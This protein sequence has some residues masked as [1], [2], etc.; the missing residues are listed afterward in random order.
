MAAHQS[1][2]RTESDSLG[3]IEIDAS[4]LWGAQTERSVRNF[5]AGQPHYVWGRGVIRSIGLVKRAAASANLDAGVLEPE[6][7]GLIDGAAS[8]VVDGAL[9]DHFPLV[10]FQT[11]SGTQ[12]NMNGNEVIANRANQRAGEPLGTKHPVHPNDHVNASQSS[13]DVFPTVM[14]LA[15]IGAL[16]AH[17]DPAIGHAVQVLDDLRERH[18]DIVKVGRTHLQDATPVTLGQ[19]IRSW[20]TQLRSARSAIATA[21][22]GLL[23]LA[24]GGT[25]TGTGLNAP[26]GFGASVASR[27]GESTGL[28]LSAADDPMA[29]TASHDAMVTVSASVRGLA[30]ACI[31][32]AN[33]VRWLGSGPRNG[34]AELILPANEPGSSIMPAKINPTQAEALTMVAA[35]VFGNDATVAFAGS[36]GS[37]QL[38]TYKPIILHATL[39][40]I[41]LL[42]DAL[43]SFTDRCLDGIEPNTTRIERNLETNLALVTALVPHIG[44][45]LASK[46]AQHAVSDGVTLRSAAADVGDVSS[47]DFDRW[48]DPRRMTD[49]H[50]R[51]DESTER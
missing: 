2:T 37:F 29:A 31:K 33:D 5:P 27:L 50:R 24:I 40:S 4:R 38:N 18:G 30:L 14:H 21:R 13:N 44:Y 11:G 42:A 49:P 7:A 35:H 48:V 8:D 36:Q 34:I 20:Q 3:S 46:V 28:D 47:D 32:I 17:L 6:V 12:T 26:E 22:R 25:A 1:T 41:T 10:V 43:V 51:P 9:D 15:T 39:D 45:D 16:D 23:T 19:E